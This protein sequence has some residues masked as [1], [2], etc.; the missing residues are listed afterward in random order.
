MT[1]HGV[2]RAR[3]YLAFMLQSCRAFWQ[4]YCNVVSTLLKPKTLSLVLGAC[5]GTYAPLSTQKVEGDSSLERRSQRVVATDFAGGGAWFVSSM[6]SSLTQTLQVNLGMRLSA[7]DANITSLIAAIIGRLSS[8]SMR[9]NMTMLE[10][11]V[12]ISLYQV[13]CQS[14]RM[15]GP[16]GEP[17]SRMML[18]ANY[19]CIAE[20][21]RGDGRDLHHR[22][23]QLP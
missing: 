10:T 1:K 5:S 9:A 19:C 18:I 15:F 17:C 13:A 2:Q 16:S 6:A 20:R 11:S 21:R 22:P 4:L 23:F 3:R 12:A 8:L 14:V 7:A